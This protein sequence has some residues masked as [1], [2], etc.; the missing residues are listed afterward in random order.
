MAGL[1]SKM[2]NSSLAT[3]K[4]SLSAESTIG[5]YAYNYLRGALYTIY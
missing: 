2:C 5:Y 4:A 1:S 3:G